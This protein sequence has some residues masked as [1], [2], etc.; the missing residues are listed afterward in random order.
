[1]KI[2]IKRDMTSLIEVVVV[3]VVVVV[4]LFCFLVLV[5]SVELYL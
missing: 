4:V 1:M 3:V 2:M 5:F